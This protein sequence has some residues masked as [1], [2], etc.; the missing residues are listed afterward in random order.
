MKPTIAPQVVWQ[1]VV[2]EAVIVDLRSGITLG[3]N[4]AG[5]FIWSQI[6]GRDASEIAAATARHFEITNEAAQSDVERF[7]NQL[8]ERELIVADEAAAR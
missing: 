2:D 1:V 5:T 4:P 8:R 3:L 7:L 6:G